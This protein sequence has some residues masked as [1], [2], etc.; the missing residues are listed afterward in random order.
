MDK[1]ENEIQLDGDRGQ[2]TTQQR[3]LADQA[4]ELAGT[5]PRILR[6]IDEQNDPKLR[7][8]KR[9][10]RQIQ[11]AL[12][13][14]QQRM[15]DKDYAASFTTA[16]TTL[17]ETRNKL[18]V[19]LNDVSQRFEDMEDRA[20]KTGDGKAIYLLPDGTGR[21]KDGQVI[22]AADMAA[23]IT[24]DDHPTWAEYEQTRERFLQLTGYAEEVD[25]TRKRLHDD[26][27]PMDKPDIDAIPDRMKEIDRDIEGQI[28]LSNEFA[29]A[30]ELSTPRIVALPTLTNSP[31][32]TN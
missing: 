2:K 31:A 24:S 8:K 27:K 12:S 1:V 10:E 9:L 3:D 23:L 30:S 32:A 16:D 21:T 26:A 18:D 29:R 11:Q 20:P 28:A 25:D 14:L 4:R 17:T 19:A 7:E 5:S 6:F 15:L 13:E 22:L